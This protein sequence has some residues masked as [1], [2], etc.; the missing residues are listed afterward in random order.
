MRIALC[1]ICAALALSVGCVT[2]DALYLPGEL[3]GFEA[4]GGAG[5]DCRVDG[6]TPATTG[7]A[8]SQ[9]PPSSVI[10]PRRSADH[11]HGGGASSTVGFNTSCDWIYD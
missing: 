2:E 1:S 9:V 10:V 7:T 11:R 6:D 8:A 3:P 5:T 4:G